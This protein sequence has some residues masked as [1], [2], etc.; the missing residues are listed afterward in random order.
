MCHPGLK[1]HIGISIRKIHDDQIG[2]RNLLAYILHYGPRNRKL[3]RTDTF[4]PVCGDSLFD[5][6]VNK[7]KF[8]LEWHNQERAWLRFQDPQIRETRLS[9]PR[10]KSALAELLVVVDHHPL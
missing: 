7:S 3:I 2:L 8:R 10:P 4:N 9:F 6:F 1:I 5:D